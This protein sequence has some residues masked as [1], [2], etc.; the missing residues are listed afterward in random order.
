MSTPTEITKELKTYPDL[1]SDPSSNPSTFPS[2]SP[3]ATTIK[4]IGNTVF[5]PLTDELPPD[6]KSLFGKLIKI[7]T[8]QSELPVFSVAKENNSKNRYSDNPPFN[9]NIYAPTQYGDK[10]L[11]P[12]YLNASKIDLTLKN[13]SLSYIATQAPLNKSKGIFG[14]HEN[15]TTEQFWKAIITGNTHL[16]VNT[17]MLREIKECNVIEKSCDYYTDF[18]WDKEKQF[19]L[20]DSFS[21]CMGTLEKIS[22]DEKVCEELKEKQ[23]ITTRQFKFIPDKNFT[24]FTE[25][26]VITHVHYENW[27][28]HDVA[29]GEQF[30]TLLRTIEEKQTP[31]PIENKQAN[32]PPFI[33]CSAGLGRT[34]V[35]IASLFL[36]EMVRQSIDTNTEPEIDIIKLINL[37]REQ[38]PLQVQNPSQLK[39]VYRALKSFAIAYAKT[40][41]FTIPKED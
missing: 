15:K 17:T 19:K 7:S 24:E 18:F 3:S 13:N 12:Y 41:D 9:N 2:P 37:M 36:R 34:G 32:F 23:K 14:S 6:F 31:L 28:D 38:R 8:K 5:K 35:V 16:I 1:T 4:E 30:D 33:H 22:S 20:Y 26:R 27:H 25:E 40:K 29:D 10:T 21:N 11:S 39:A